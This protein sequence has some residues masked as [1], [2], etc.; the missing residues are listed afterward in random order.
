M[1]TPYRMRFDEQSFDLITAWRH[2]KLHQ[3]ENICRS[4]E[5]FEKGG[6]LFFLVTNSES[7]YGRKA[8]KED[9]P[10]HLY[11]FSEKILRLYAINSVS[12]FSYR[13]R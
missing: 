4:G 7:L 5:I 2:G 9:V 12:I 10:R 8:F 13:I 1:Q 11:H 6:K 3:P